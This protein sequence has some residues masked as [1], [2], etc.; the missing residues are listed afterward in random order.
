MTPRLDD[1]KLL[2]RDFPGFNYLK[3]HIANSPFWSTCAKLDSECTSLDD[4]IDKA[5][6]ILKTGAPSAYEKFIDYKSFLDDFPLKGAFSPKHK[7]SVKEITPLDSE[8][9]DFLDTVFQI[10]TACV[11][12]YQKRLNELENLLQQLWDDLNPPDKIEDMIEQGSCSSPKC[13][14]KLK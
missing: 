9:I 7:S 13:G 8:E 12:N 2:E 10:F 14:L 6:E 1:E 3:Q 5:V 4:D 11:P